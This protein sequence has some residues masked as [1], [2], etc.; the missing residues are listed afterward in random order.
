MNI[1]NDP[2][3]K[4]EPWK[5]SLNVREI[6]L[7]M[8]YRDYV[9][10]NALVFKCSCCDDWGACLADDPTTTIPC[11]NSTKDETVAELRKY[12]FTVVGEYINNRPVLY[13]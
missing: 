6:T 11:S 4:E 13:N 3:W 2:K 12:G 5:S 1:L 10:G 8:A 7:L 9:N